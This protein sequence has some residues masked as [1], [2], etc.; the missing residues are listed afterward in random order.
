MER[1][2]Y[3]FTDDT[4]AK[5]RGSSAGRQD[6][7]HEPQE[8]LE[9]S[10]PRVQEFLGPQWARAAYQEFVVD[11]PE[12]FVRI[13]ARVNV[14]PRTAWR[15]QADASWALT[16]ELERDRDETVI[17]EIGLHTYESRILTE[18]RRRAHHHY[19]DCPQPDDLLGWLAFL[20]HEGA[21]TRLLDVT[22]SP[23]VAAFF[24]TS[25]EH[26]ARDGAVWMFSQFH[27]SNGLHTA[28]MK[29]EKPFFG[30]GA[31]G[32]VLDGYQP[33]TPERN[34]PESRAVSRHDILS[35]DP[36][37]LLA[38]ATRGMLAVHAVMLVEPGRW[39]SRR[40]DVQQ[41]AFLVPLNLRSGSERNLAETIGHP[42]AQPSDREVGPFPR[43]EKHISTVV[44]NAAVIKLRVLAAAKSKLRSL[45]E[46]M[47]VRASVLFP[48][49]HGF[50][51]E[52]RSLLPPKGTWPPG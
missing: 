51:M 25:V 3:S 29:T 46:K 16:T 50:V 47:N 18:A 10:D 1:R 36:L 15:G 19:A 20:R 31:F 43:D 6:A 5:V 35:G 12:E 45:L 39:M 27:L 41:G 13:A 22:W 52:L 9:E 8:E 33:P 42:M 32:V 21:P 24:A 14:S 38:L 26:D 37:L 2:W 40:H 34:T 23:S 4:R 28:L 48:D 11:S 49:H 7:S 17:R 44:G 30:D